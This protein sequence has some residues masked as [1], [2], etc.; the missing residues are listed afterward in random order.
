MTAPSRAPVINAIDPSWSLRSGDHD[1]S[2]ATLTG[3]GS[4]QPVRMWSRT[5][6]DGIRGYSS[7][8][9]SG[10]TIVTWTS[11]PT[12]LEPF[13]DSTASHFSASARRSDPWASSATVAPA[14]HREVPDRR[15]SAHSV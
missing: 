12:S 15:P 14:D 5:R 11:R 2:E 6:L 1:R 7:P 10:T 4:Q 13:G 8:P 3:S 9:P